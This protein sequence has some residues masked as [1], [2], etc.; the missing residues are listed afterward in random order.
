MKT[1]L[2][3]FISLCITMMLQAQISKTIEVT[4]G[5]L[6]TAL[7]AEE[8]ST[9][10]NLTLT[11]TIDARDFK[12][13]RD[14][15]PVLEV[16]N[17][18]AVTI[19]EYSGTDGTADESNHIYMVNTV[20]E[21]SFYTLSQSKTSLKFVILPLSITS[22]GVNAF[23]GCTGLALVTIPLPV[24]SIGAGAFFNC[25]A[26]EKI[27]I[28]SSVTF[29]GSAAFSF[30]T[31]LKS[32]VSKSSYP[33]DLN[34][35]PDVFLAV[36]NTI[37]TLNVPYNAQHLYS[38][39]EQWKDF[40][41][42][43]EETQGI[44]LDKTKVNVTPDGGSTNINITAN[45][46]WTA[47][48]DKNWLLVNPSSGTNNQTLTFTAEAN[49]SA[50]PR[51]AKVTVSATG[52]DSRTVSVSQEGIIKIAAVT[53]GGLK[54]ALTTDEL[55][56]VK[57]LTLTGT[58]D[59]RDF[60]TMRDD[61][62]MLAEIDL[63]GVII[64][65]Y[66]GTEGTWYESVSVK[67]PANAIPDF[68]FYNL[69]EDKIKTTLISFIFPPK[70][71]SIGQN[72]FFACMN[73]LSLNI[74]NSVTEIKSLGFGACFKSTSVNIPASVTSIDNSAFLTGGSVNV[75]INNPNYS[76][77]N[78]V[79]FNKLQTVLIHCPVSKTGSY[80]I[81]GSVY[82]IESGSFYHSSL[83]SVTIPSSISSI[84]S[85]AFWYSTNIS[86]IIVKSS[87]P[88]DLSSSTEVF[89]GIDKTTCTLYLPYGTKKLY[90]AANQW[91][92][93]TNIVEASNG[94]NL[95]A[96]A[97]SIAVTGG[98]T[99]NVDLSANVEWTAS[100]D[101]TWLT[102]NPASGNDNHTL[103]F[104]AEA[105]SSIGTRIATV[106]VSATGYDSQT[107]K[108][109]QDGTNLPVNITAGGLKALFTTE[110]L[111]T[112]TKLT[113]TG[114]I[115][116]RDFKTMRD[117]MPLLT[118]IDLSGANVAAYNG[119]GGTSNWGNTF[120]AADAIPEFA[121]SDKKTLTSC[122][123]PSSITSIQ[124]IAFRS[125][126]GLTS[127]SIPSLVTS[128]SQ[129]AFAF[130][131][132]LTSISIP[133]SVKSISIFAFYGCRCSISIPSSVTYIGGAAFASVGGEI[134]V[135][136]NNPNYSV[137][138]GVLFD[139]TQTK[140]IQFPISKSGDYIIPLTVKSI[141]YR[142]FN[143]CEK[144]TSIV[145]PSSVNSIETNA[146]LWCYGLTSIYAKSNLPIDLSSSEKVFVMV[147]YRTCTLYVPYGS[148][149]LYA[150]ANQ[151]KDFKNIVEF[152]FIELYAI[153][154]SI[155]A[156][157][158]S[159]AEV[160]INS[161]VTWTAS[162]D[163]SWLT[164]NPTSGTDKQTLILTADANPSHL[165]R[166]A[167][168]TISATD[169]DSQTIFVTQA[170]SPV[171][172][173]AGNLETL[174]SAE[175]L[176]TITRLKLTGTIDARDFK[177]MRDD[178]PNLKEIDLSGVTVVE[179]T[180][181]EGTSWGTVYPANEI[182]DD[183]FFNAAKGS[184]KIS[185]T[186]FIFPSAVTSIGASAFS[187]CLS[188][189][190]SLPPSV[191]SINVAAFNRCSYITVDNGNQNYSSI[192]GVLFNKNQTRFIQCIPSKSGNYNIP[193]SVISIGYAAF[194]GCNSLT[195][196]IVPESVL[197]IEIGALS[198]STGMIIVDENNLNYSSVDGVLFDK[199]KST[200][201]QC[202]TSKTGTYTIPS[203][204]TTIG[205]Y[206]FCL[207][208]NLTSVN[209]PMSVTTIGELAFTNC[210]SLT[211]INIP[212]SITYI[213]TWAFFSCENL[214]SITV[215][216]YL[217]L[218]LS[219]SLDVFY[220]IN[221]TTC[222]L[223]VPYGSK[224]LYA[225]ANQWQDFTNIVEMPGFKF[226]ASTT[227]VKSKQG[228]TSEI[229]ISSNTTWSVSSEQSWLKVSPSSGTGNQ[230]LTF[231]ADGNPVNA[232]RTATVTVSV[233]GV[234][235]QT[236]TVTQ[237]A[238]PTGLDDLADIS[239]QFKCYPNPF[240]DEITIE[241]QNLKQVET[242]V[243][244]YNLAGER[245]KNLATKRKDEKL[246]LKWNGTNESGQK[247]APVVYVCKVNKQAKQLVY[248]GQKG[249]KQ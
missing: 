10:T 14:D 80:I 228:S 98:V 2:L 52:V 199:S 23:S 151:W 171:E 239:T 125:C 94:F 153:D 64:M 139:K 77:L 177:T 249:N 195:S 53:A 182:P 36:N 138:D 49:I 122:I 150:S 70:V 184:S 66:T 130:C 38:S 141:G 37:C 47:S 5:G 133:S 178:M 1:T 100:S 246:E 19:S 76:S 160:K 215:E 92:D 216:R 179:Y 137:I 48:S 60:K 189:M 134:T 169:L 104:I 61:M 221:N 28:P 84:G 127:V 227:S 238:W 155:A 73:L 20:P 120:Y 224:S 121:F 213:R 136:S 4:A 90:K 102:V 131:S 191:I 91:Q 208:Y 176:A 167:Q 149:A 116:A 68:A 56:S 95:S 205:D 152:P 140:L 192:D 22:I 229:N 123:F 93:F 173:T 58:I 21:G 196:I 7:N 225:S 144:L 88:I 27:T 87:H 35:S 3:I 235:S 218:N 69:N 109:I 29:I 40:L 174:L 30:C 31:G 11:G 9:V 217:P 236:I 154:I 103:T 78:G 241:I 193:N 142:A 243:D 220:G 8:L 237:D 41:S 128:I 143:G 207:C 43:S 209:L 157:Y 18:S 59:A 12:T 200:L 82:T 54:A 244:I 234:N 161:D 219:T 247:V 233:P 106:T 33:V 114:T 117:D 71:T 168:I 42:I 79:L 172:A 135:D 210:V 81:P 163:Q 86:S 51:T 57:N 119:S 158:G 203:S 183:A 156:A 115:D 206:A 39:A 190:V 242:S 214:D 187:G 248:L 83:T 44:L 85:S 146:F 204:V 15:I 202:T 6:K 107:I 211:S 112:I 201:I 113:L 164:L 226:S 145:I 24:T 63:S 147:N 74:P 25:S 105:N 118:E 50:I 55:R 159:K 89:T 62:P 13:M 96:S 223:Y 197:S 188:L 170:A 186:S 231:T 65:T 129:S 180:G 67:Y 185:L 181:I 198:G 75:D 194:Y 110:E 245:I 240:T 108:I 212:S 166:N 101:Q 124:D 17:L 99:D 32:I 165:E 232:I 111:S 162:S 126:S 16:L 26:L 148:K 97:V 46:S 72:A 34:S 132:G 230:I 222:T 45:V 175:E